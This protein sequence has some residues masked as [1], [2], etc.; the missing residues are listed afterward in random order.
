MSFYEFLR[1][2][3]YIRLVMPFMVGILIGHLLDVNPDNNWIF[4]WILPFLFAG[5]FL[6]F[7]NKYQLRWIW[8][9]MMHLFIIFLGVTAYTSCQSR[10][11]LPRE[12][13]IAQ[14]TIIENPIE[15]PNGYRTLV[16]LNALNENGKWQ[17][18]D[19]RI[20]L[21]LERKP[22]AQ[23]PLLNQQLLI[24]GFLKEIKNFGNP[25]EFDY[26]GF[27]N[28]TGVF[29]RAFIDSA[30]WHVSGFNSKFNLVVWAL[31]LRNSILNNF[32][33][34]NLDQA[35]FAVISAL[36]VG[37]KSHLDQEL[38]SAYVN[39]GTMHILAV[40]GMHV[41][42]LFWLLQQLTRPLML[43]RNGKIYRAVI[44]LVVIWVYALVTGLTPSVVRASVMF[45]FWMLGETGRRNVNIYNT[46]SASA[47]LLLVINPQNLFD[48]G[49]Q[50]S[51]MAVLSIV[52][53][54]K[55]I[56]NWFSPRNWFLKQGW[57]MVAVSLAAQ[58]FTLPLSLF[59][60][61]QFPNYFLLS[62]IVALPLTTFILYGSISAL[63]I[64]PFK[65]LWIP[66]GYILNGMVGFLNAA[67]IWVEHLPGA[68]STGL[69]VSW[70][71][72]ISIFVIIISIRVFI[73]NRKA[74][75]IIAVFAC[76][77]VFASDF[78][79]KNYKIINSSEIVFYNTS[80]PLVIQVR[81]GF[82]S[83]V[84]TNSP[85]YD[86]ER[87]VKP[88]NEANWVRNFRK[89]VLDRDT[90]LR[91]YDIA[92]YKKFLFVGDLKVYV[93]EQVPEFSTNSDVDVLIINRFNLKHVDLVNKYFSPKHFLVTSSVFLPARDSLN[94]HFSSKK[95]PGKTLNIDGA[96]VYTIPKKIDK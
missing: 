20:L 72:A 41:A 61:H 10:P 89:I 26:K 44:V 91:E 76:C 92:Y 56:H 64:I 86:V 16:R 21:T 12:K 28:R 84:I 39:S 78:L 30:N 66:V 82:N 40:S 11:L 60:F 1:S 19:D 57:N 54:Y 17:V 69:S 49:F 25:N 43:V 29:Y 22:L 36:T 13:I 14:C 50:L 35:S 59:Y 24:K 70:I 55:D 58:L 7:G 71:M 73:F 90:V 8:G 45:T 77:I 96:W 51:Y 95:I 9:L 4:F 63:L 74:I 68:V 87:L 47:L 3:P 34:L 46:L 79:L 6:G 15:K 85:G 37:D 65:F 53:F 81:N 42:L 88:Y 83:L 75:H 31:E 18:A 32:R 93:W 48:V 27:M 94:K 80:G 62:N 5:L 67:L 23:V 38:K 52:V 33:K 2:A